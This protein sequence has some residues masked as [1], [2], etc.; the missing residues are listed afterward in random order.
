MDLQ[1]L[2]KD[3]ILPN[4]WISEAKISNWD[5][6]VSFRG[7]ESA[8]AANE[9]QADYLTIEQFYGCKRHMSMNE[10][11]PEAEV[12]ADELMAFSSYLG[13]SIDEVILPDIES[14]TT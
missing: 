14:S 6:I 7:H 9:L 12:A 13:N 1:N 5:K 3:S 11:M 10:L 8:Y 4:T 2:E